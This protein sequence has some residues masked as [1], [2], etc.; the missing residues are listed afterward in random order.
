MIHLYLSESINLSAM[1]FC[2]P[3]SHKLRTIT[4]FNEVVPKKGKL[5]KSLNEETH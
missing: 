4:V 5:F 2:L 3:K 1:S